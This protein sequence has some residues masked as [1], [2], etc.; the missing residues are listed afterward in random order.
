MM[1]IIL[2][3]WIEKERIWVLCAMGFWHDVFLSVT[4]QGN[5]FIFGQGTKLTVEPG[6]SN[7]QNH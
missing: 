4:N 3:M 7:S 5:K 2:V 1:I 6:K